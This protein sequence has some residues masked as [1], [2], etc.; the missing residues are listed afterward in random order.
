[1]HMC[2]LPLDHILHAIWGRDEPSSLLLLDDRADYSRGSPAFVYHS[3]RQYM[4][5]MAQYSEHC[6]LLGFEGGELRNIDLRMQNETTAISHDPF[7]PAIGSIDFSPA[8]NVFTVSGLSE[9][10]AAK[11][12]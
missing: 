11:S 9:Y 2:N 8:G 4:Y 3:G 6:V 5:A 10:V 7:V 1:M 12:Q